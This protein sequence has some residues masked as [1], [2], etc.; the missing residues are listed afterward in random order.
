MPFHVLVPKKG[1][2][3]GKQP[4]AV[5][6]NLKLG[7]LVLLSTV[8]V[9]MRRT[10]GKEI[11]YIRLL[12]DDEQPDVFLMQPCE[13]DAHGARRIDHTP[14]TTPSISARYLFN[15]LGLPKEGLR[16]CPVSWDEEHE[17]WLVHWKESIEVEDMV[18]PVPSRSRKVRA[19]SKKQD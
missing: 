18:L 8:Y 13:E 2:L 4:Q 6:L 17:G 11:Q 12:T 1:R 3:G 19:P 9:I 7:R 16:R 5:T 10:F 14:G 15:Q